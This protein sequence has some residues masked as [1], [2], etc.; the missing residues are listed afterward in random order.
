LEA[1]ALAVADAGWKLLRHLR[2]AELLAFGLDEDRTRGIEMLQRA[3]HQAVEH[4]LR[5]LR[6]ARKLAEQRAAVAGEALQVEHLRALCRERGEEPALA[7]PGGAAH[8]LEEETLRRA[9]ELR[10]DFAAVRPAAAC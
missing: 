2:L 8:R 1:Q 10:N 6:L 5:G 7:A 9:I 4:L 3:P